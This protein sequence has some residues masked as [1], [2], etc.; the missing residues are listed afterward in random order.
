MV[1]KNIFISIVIPF[2]NEKNNL[3][4]LLPKLKKS[5][6]TIKNK[7]EVIFIDDGSRDNSKKIIEKFNIKNKNCKLIIHKNNLGQT[8]CYKSA[9]KIC[10]GEFFLRLDSDL[11]DNPKDIYKFVK[12]FK[13]GF[14]LV[15]GYRK[16]RKH[17]FLLLF[18][19]FIFD[20]VISLFSKTKLKSYTGS[21]VGFRTKYL[22]NKKFKRNDHR[23]FPLVYI[24]SNKKICE[25]IIGHKARI[26][27]TSYYSV[28]SKILFALPELVSFLIRLKF[29]KLR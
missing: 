23:Y 14:D 3:R 28:V 16:N 9:L 24:L 27:G 10:K 19:S 25:V 6:K 5:L 18:L 21:F 20:L 2:F 26:Y 1:K 11:Q 7:Y 12:S 17:K 22:I 4:I 8:E 13:K 15:I 29:F